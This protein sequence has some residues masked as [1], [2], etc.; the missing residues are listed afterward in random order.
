MQLMNEPRR[1]WERNRYRNGAIYV[2]DPSAHSTPMD[3]NRRARLLQLAESLERRTKAAGRRNGALGQI[4]LQVLRALVLRF[5]NSR[6]GLCCPSIWKLQLVTGL[7]R[8]AVCDALARLERSGLVKI[9]RRIVRATLE[10]VSPITGEM[11]RYVGT[12]QS[13]N[14]YGFAIEEHAIEWREIDRLLPPAN[15]RPFPVRRQF[16]FAERIFGRASGSAG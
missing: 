14:L 4:G 5:H 3:R 15:A 6:T 13:S 10:R 2:R 12:I 16:T 9:T 8:G 1:R 7:S 11:Q